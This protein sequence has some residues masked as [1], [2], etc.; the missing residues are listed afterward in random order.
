MLPRL[1]EQF[2]P[3]SYHPVKMNCNHFSDALCKELIGA[4]IPAW[5]NRPATIGRFFTFG[6]GKAAAGGGV[7]E[8]GGKQEKGAN[9]DK[10][11]RQKKELTEEQKRRLEAIRKSG[12]S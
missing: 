2:A 6:R 9:A 11:A 1:R 8:K 5:I 7:G 10:G 3:G 4:P 12:A